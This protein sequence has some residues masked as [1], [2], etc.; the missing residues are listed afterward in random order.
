M[1]STT[2]M[3]LQSPDPSRWPSDR[4]LRGYDRA[5]SFAKMAASTIASRVQVGMSE[6]DAT[7]VTKEV[8]RELGVLKHWHM[9]VIGAG[10]G[11]MKF[12]SAGRLLRSFVGSSKR[13]VG[14]GDVLFIDIA[15]FFEGYPSDFTLTTSTAKTSASTT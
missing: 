4:D 8:F 12:T 11:S 1:N 5:Q 14:D 9:P 10:G 3:T 13:L 7:N 2:A 6:R 15:P